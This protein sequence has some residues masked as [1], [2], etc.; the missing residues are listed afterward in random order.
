MELGDR[1]FMLF[2]VKHRSAEMPRGQQLALERVIDALSKVRHAILIMFDH[3]VTP[4]QKIDID[5]ANCIVR[6]YRTNSQWHNGNGKT[7]VEVTNEFVGRKAESQRC[8][9]KS[10]HN[11]IADNWGP[12]L[13][14]SGQPC[15]MNFDTGETW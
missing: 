10:Q 12:A 2:E 15:F 5:V 1:H 4:E 8:D 11:V 7:V 3:D 9:D 14:S 6:K 13:N